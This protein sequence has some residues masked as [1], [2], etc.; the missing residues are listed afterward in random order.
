MPIYVMSCFKLPKTF[1]AEINVLMARFW[2]EDMGTSRKLHWKNWEALCVSK[3]EIRSQA[4]N[5]AM[6]G[7]QWWRLMQNYPQSLSFKVF[8]ADTFLMTVHG[9]S[10]V[11]RELLFFGKA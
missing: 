7:K 8:K 9:M 3:R 10:N 4:F 5:I 11:I 6:L 2:W 1:L